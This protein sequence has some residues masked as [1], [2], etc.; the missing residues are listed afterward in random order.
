MSQIN[1]LDRYNRLAFHLNFQDLCRLKENIET[2]CSILKNYATTNH[3]D[4]CSTRLFA[5]IVLSNFVDMISFGRCRQIVD[6]AFE[7]L[8][9]CYPRLIKPIVEPIPTDPETGFPNKEDLRSLS[10]QFLSEIA[11]LFQLQLYLANDQSIPILSRSPSSDEGWNVTQ[12]CE[13]ARERSIRA[14]LLELRYIAEM[15]QTTI[16]E[17]STE[18]L[19]ELIENANSPLPLK[20]GPLDP[21]RENRFPSPSNEEI[22]RF[23]S[24][25]L[26]IPF[27]EPCALT[28]NP[29]ILEKIAVHRN[30][31]NNIKA[32]ILTDVKEYFEHCMLRPTELCDIGLFL[33]PDAEP[34]TKKTLIGL[35]AG[36]Y[37]IPTNSHSKYLFGLFSGE[38]A[39]DID[40]V[41]HGNFTRFINH[42]DPG[43]ITPELVYIQDPTDPRFYIPQ[44]ALFAEN[45]KPGE[46]FLY[47]YGKDYW[48]TLGIEPLPIHPKSIYFAP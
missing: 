42:G 16:R 23:H 6:E 22:D 14:P 44:V 11:R 13:I 41:E 19:V 15:N 34:I 31:I 32:P 21:L 26:E 18:Q 24:E 40:A 47:N 28:D 10:Y 27:L 48:K 46:Q 43:N 8:S 38:P 33:R 36:S 45:V 4:G 35:Y 9:C 39:I 17:T 30:D 3:P 25:I 2:V 1:A 29:K 12:I 5:A 7:G 20:Q 37:I